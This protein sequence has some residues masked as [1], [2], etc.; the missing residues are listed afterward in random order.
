MVAAQLPMDV[1]SCSRHQQL[2]VVLVC[3]AHAALARMHAYLLA[4]ACVVCTQLWR[5]TFADDAGWW[6]RMVGL[7]AQRLPHP[8]SWHSLTLLYAA[9]TPSL[10]RRAASSSGGDAAAEEAAELQRLLHPAAGISPAHCHC[11][12]CRPAADSA[13][14]CWPSSWTCQDAAWACKLVQAEQLLESAVHQLLS[15]GADSSSELYDKLAAMT[16]QQVA[17]QVCVWGGGRGCSSLCTSPT[18]LQRQAL[19]M[20]CAGGPAGMAA[21]A[22]P[23]SRRCTQPCR[24]RAGARA[25]RAAA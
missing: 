23:A 12:R 13:G 7:L 11:P 19:H 8:D 22:R 6:Q 3:A 9:E 18:A 4:H 15:A 14:G 5:G 16:K 24:A 21:G 17:M 20:R 10:T 25:A 2:A 1:V